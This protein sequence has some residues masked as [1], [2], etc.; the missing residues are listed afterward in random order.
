ML[1]ID[2]RSLLLEFY[3]QPLVF[4]IFSLTYPSNSV[5][6]RLVSA[7][8]SD[9]LPLLI[10][11]LP[12]VSLLLLMIHTFAAHFSYF[13]S[14]KSPI[15]TSQL[16]MDWSVPLDFARV[17]LF[18]RF[19]WI[20]SITYRNLSDSSDHE[21]CAMT[22]AGDVHHDDGTVTFIDFT[23]IEYSTLIDYFRLLTCIIHLNVPSLE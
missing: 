5:A 12:S 19:Q 20:R 22:T 2:T 4:I 7:S 10:F 1:N 14:P 21:Q 18:P 15:S 13:P 23:S 3:D 16:A 17:L 8:S 6:F 9:V 11:F